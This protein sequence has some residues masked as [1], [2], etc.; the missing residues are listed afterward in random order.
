MADTNNDATLT[1]TAVGATTIANVTQ[2]STTGTGSGAIFT[3]AIDGA[4][5]YS[6]TSINSAGTGYE[7]GDSI[8]VSG[9]NLGG[10]SSSNDLTVLVE[11]IETLSGAILHLMTYLSRAM[12]RRQQLYQAL[13]SQLR[14]LQPRPL[15]L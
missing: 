6:V 10:T 9:A 15:Q 11:N 3:I 2:T 13:M 14:I 8:T 7:E 1:L 5:N 12:M 4:G